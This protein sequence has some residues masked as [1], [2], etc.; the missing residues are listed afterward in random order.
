MA[1][2]N[3]QNYSLADY[4]ANIVHLGSVDL[5]SSILHIKVTLSQDNYTES[6]ATNIDKFE[7]LLL[8]IIQ[9]Q[10]FTLSS[11]TS[12]QIFLQTIQS[13]YH[14]MI[15]CLDHTDTTI[16]KRLSFDNYHELTHSFNNLFKI[17]GHKFNLPFEHQ[18]RKIRTKRGLFDAVGLGEKYLFGVATS[19][20]VTKL[21]NNVNSK[22]YTL[23]NKIKKIHESIV[24]F[25]S[26]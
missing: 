23:D 13:A 14:H 6:L 21:S 8:N 24:I 2:D 1:D 10:Q 22:I 19:D 26:R 9:Q 3:H 15:S 25:I 11:Y 17:L 7:T 4:G 20:D 16:Y 5:T 12:P 18:N